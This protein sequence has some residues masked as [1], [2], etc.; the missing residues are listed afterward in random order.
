[1][2]NSEF[3]TEQARATQAS[4]QL[5]RSNR[6]QDE[7]RAAKRNRQ[8]DGRGSGGA[9]SSDQE[10]QLAQALGWFSIGLGLIE[11]LAPRQLVKIIGVDNHSKLVRALGIR[12]IATGIGILGQR[13]QPAPW[14]WARVAGDVIDLA[15]LG[16]ALNSSTANKGRVAAAAGAVAGV[17]VLDVRCSRRLSRK[18]ATDQLIRLNQSITINR[19]A[20][21]L[22]RFWRELTNLPRFMYH[23]ESVQVTGNKRSH[24]VAKAP[25]G[26]KVEWDAEITEERPNELIAWRSVG[27]TEVENSGSVRFERAPG[28]RGTVVRVEIRYRP[29]IGGIAP[30]IA[31]LFGEEPE[32][33]VAED[34]RRFKQL[35]EAGEILTTEGQPAGRSRSTSWKYDQTVRPAAAS[36]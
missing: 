3:Q 32:Q 14:L 34:L 19:S 6:E 10:E 8:D 20:E 4:S 17:T 25:A 18:T 30:A 26:M 31:K 16:I 28:G 12:E 36:G 24:W 2:A 1:M 13:Q 23:L 33:Q 29:P 11:V 7:T 9:L 5:W 27:R 21:E 22:Y 35:M 15:A